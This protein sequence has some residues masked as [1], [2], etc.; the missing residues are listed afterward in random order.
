MHLA[1][2]AAAAFTLPIGMAN[3]FG[4]PPESGV[5]L[6]LVGL[7]AAS[8]GLPFV[9]LSAS[10]PLLQSWFAASGHRA[11]AQPL[12]PLRRLQSRLVRRAARLSAGDR[13]A[14]AAARQAWVWSVGFAG[15]AV[16]VAHRGA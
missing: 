10:A 15:L 2:L 12:R 13:V 16:L 4:A 5:G 6:W 14:A 7:F 9:A 11:G 1:V 8:I 3:G